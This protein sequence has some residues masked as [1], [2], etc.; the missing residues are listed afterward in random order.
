MEQ[1]TADWTVSRLTKSLR[2]RTIL[3]GIGLS[4]SI[5][6]VKECN[7]HAQSQIHAQKRPEKNPKPPVVDLQSLHKWKGKSKAELLA[8][9]LNA[10]EVPQLRANLLRKGEYFFIIVA[11]PGI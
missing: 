3:K 9:R 8:A 7:V 6:Y 5:P 1:E 11:V 10:K 4:H 2:R